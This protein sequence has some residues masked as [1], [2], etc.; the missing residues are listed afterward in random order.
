MVLKLAAFAAFCWILARFAEERFTSWISR[1]QRPPD[2]ILSI[3]GVGFGIAAL[4]HLKCVGPSS[5]RPKRLGRQAVA[6]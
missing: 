1:A 6:R 3:V 5:G 4:A 2:R